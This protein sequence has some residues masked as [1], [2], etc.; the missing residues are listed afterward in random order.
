MSTY[1]MSDLHGEADMFHQMLQKINLTDSDDLYIL[2][3]VIDRGPDG[4]ALIHEIMATPNIH[5]LMGNHEYMMIQYLDPNATVVEIL[6]WGNNGNEPTLLAFDLLEKQEKDEVLQYIQNLPTHVELDLNGKVFYLVHA[7]PGENVHDE[8]WVRPAI[9]TA[10]PMSG[11][12]LIIGHTPVLNL[13]YSKESRVEYEE[14]MISRGE[15]PKIYHAEGFIDIDCGC[16]YRRPLKTLGCLRLD[17]M[18]EFYVNS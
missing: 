11:K 8:V 6:R 17:D 10:N 14:Q 16:S 13:L 18:Q 4:I 12:V 5:M 1:V 2:G 15:H 9:D 7:F 3:D